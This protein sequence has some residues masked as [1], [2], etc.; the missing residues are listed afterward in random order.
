MGWRFPITLTLTDRELKTVQD[1]D[2]D[3]EEV[4]RTAIRQEIRN[5]QEA[6]SLVQGMDLFAENK[7]LRDR[8]DRM[9]AEIRALRVGEQNFTN[10]AGIPGI[11]E[12]FLE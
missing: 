12:A 1:S 10:F 11:S 7:R 6:Q 9:E 3:C 4:A 8:L 5:W 2:M